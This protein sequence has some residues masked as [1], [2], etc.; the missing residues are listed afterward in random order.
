MSREGPAGRWLLVCIQKPRGE[1]TGGGGRRVEHHTGPY[2]HDPLHPMPRQTVLAATDAA[3][4]ARYH[5][6]RSGS[7]RFMTQPNTYRPVWRAVVRTPQRPSRY[8]DRRLNTR[9]PK[10]GIERAF[11]IALAPRRATRLGRRG[12]VPGR[13]SWP[14]SL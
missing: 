10:A 6:G 9:P 3:A 7:Y 14:L 8:P 5:I 4:P 11:T 2:H 12:Q 13:F 1:V